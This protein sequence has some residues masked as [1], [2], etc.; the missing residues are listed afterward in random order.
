MK[1]NPGSFIHNYNNTERHYS[2]QIAD[3]LIHFELHGTDGEAHSS[4]QYDDKKALVIIFTCNH[5][6]YARAYVSRIA[7]LV[8][9]YESRGVGFFAISSNDVVQ[10]PADSLENMHEVGKLMHLNG[11]YLYDESQEVARAYGAQR[12]PEVFVFDVNRKLA[13]H[14]AID[15]NWEHADK[16]TETYVA[17]ALDLLL[18]GKEPTI[19]ET[20]AVGCTIKWKPAM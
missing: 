1:E 9:N 2:M 4:H 15:N 19:K 14:G 12:T 11:H 7:R 8:D 6:P 3:N 18:Q 13:Y 17:N 20:P 10:Y 5:C 16:V